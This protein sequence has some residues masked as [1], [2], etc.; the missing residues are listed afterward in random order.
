MILLHHTLNPNLQ[1]RLL[2]Q[3]INNTPTYIYI[4]LQYLPFFLFC[5]IVVNIRTFL[6]F[7]DDLLEE[8]IELLKLFMLPFEPRLVRDKADC[9]GNVLRPSFT[10]NFTLNISEKYQPVGPISY[11]CNRNESSFFFK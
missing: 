11:L 5:S 4:A 8:A 3:Y 7:F 10:L 1:V 6:S 2:R 9:F